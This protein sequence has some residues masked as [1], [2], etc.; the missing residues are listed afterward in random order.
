MYVIAEKL[1]AKTKMI[2]LNSP[3]NPTGAVITKKELKRLADLAI[4]KNILILSDEVYEHFVY[5]NDDEHKS[6][7]IASLGEE[8]KKLTITMNSFSKTYAMTGW[9]IGYCAS[10]KK[11]AAAMDALQSHMTSNPT[12]FAQYG[13]VAALTMKEKSSAFVNTMI[14]EFKK[15]REVMVNRLN[16]CDGVECAM[17][18]GAF[19]AFPNI[20]RFGKTSRELASYLLRDVGVALLDGIFI[21][22]LLNID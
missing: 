8:I 1:T 4:E 20:K 7:S 3:S 9:R 19:Y 14:K 6:R 2:V 16:E 21:L 13:A 15:R 5:E 22:F 10:E 17:P 12:T 18:S 11:I